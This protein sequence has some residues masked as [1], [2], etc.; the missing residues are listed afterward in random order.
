MKLHIFKNEFKQ[1]ILFS[2]KILFFSLIARNVK[3]V[4][5][6]YCALM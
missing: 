4:A 1:Q 3:R 5:K 2:L 6:N